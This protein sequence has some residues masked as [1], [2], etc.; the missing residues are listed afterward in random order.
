[1]AT[2]ETREPIARSRRRSRRQILATLGGAAALGIDDRVG[3]L[4]SGKDA[5]IAAFR[6]DGARTVPAGDPEAA[7]LFALSGRA[8]ELVTVRGKRLVEKGKTVAKMEA[9]LH[10]VAAA[11][12]ALHTWAETNLG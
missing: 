7:A 5:D 4:E 6:L 2:D 12:V 9:L 3:S 1:M 8:A 10:T 11:S